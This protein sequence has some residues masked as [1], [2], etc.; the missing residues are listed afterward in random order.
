MLA[1]AL[2]VG[3]AGPAAGTGAGDTL[4]VRNSSRKTPP[5]Q[6]S[7]VQAKWMDA[8][9]AANTTRLNAGVT[10]S[11]VVI[12]L[13]LLDVKAA[14]I[15][16]L[17]VAGRYIIRYNSVGTSGSYRS[18]IDSRKLLAQALNL[19]E[20]GR[21]DGEVWAGEKRWSRMMWTPGATT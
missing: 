3:C 18:D 16:R 1:A 5:I 13:D 9:G 21:G 17:R 7:P 10:P 8:L 15:A 2:L 20:V 6:K 19:G 11:G 4:A 12:S 14:G